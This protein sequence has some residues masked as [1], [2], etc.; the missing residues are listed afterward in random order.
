MFVWTSINMNVQP[1]IEYRGSGNNV[2]TRITNLDI[3]AES[4]R[5]PPEDIMRLLSRDFGA[6]YHQDTIKGSY[7]SSELASRLK[8]YRFR[9]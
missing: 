2:T 8:R 1:E 9:P 4:L 5:G 3:V 7:S 6:V